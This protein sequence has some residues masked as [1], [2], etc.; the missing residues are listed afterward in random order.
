MIEV[1]GIR[2]DKT[3]EI[4]YVGQTSRGH[5]QRFREHLNKKGFDETEYSVVVLKECSVDELDKWEKH[6]IKKYNTLSKWNKQEGGKNPRGYNIPPRIQ[7]EE[8]IEWRRKWMKE[9]NPLSNPETRK[10]HSKT[11]SELYSSGKLENPMA[12]KWLV[13]YKN[14]NSEIVVSLKKWCREKSYNYMAL[15]NGRQDKDIVRVTKL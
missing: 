4:V 5:R 12:K 15:Y 1:Y 7:S 8:E 3:N 11:M 13:E 6:F 9:N 2:E 10:K 14:G